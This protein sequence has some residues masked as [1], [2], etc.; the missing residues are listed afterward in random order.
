MH[1]KD[2][3][4]LILV[5]ACSWRLM[6]MPI[7]SGRDGKRATLVMPPWCAFQGAHL[8][9]CVGGQQC[10]FNGGG[11]MELSAGNSDKADVWPTLVA[12]TCW[13]VDPCASRI[14]QGPNRCWR[15]CSKRMCW[16]QVHSVSFMSAWIKGFPACCCHNMITVHFSSQRRC[17]SDSGRPSAKEKQAPSRRPSSLCKINQSLMLRQLLI[18]C[19]VHKETAAPV[20]PPSEWVWVWL[21]L[22]A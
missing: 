1:R 8:W 15:S 21:I 16:N 11:E 9:C 12:G 13:D 19:R 14:N 7:A 3:F 5:I 2:L 22:L 20:C 6:Q 10:R 4:G 17:S 18:C